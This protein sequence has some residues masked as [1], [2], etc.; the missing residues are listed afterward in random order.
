[1]K[2][3]FVETIVHKAEGR[4][5]TF[6]MGRE[7]YGIEIQRVREIMGFAAIE[8][9]A[10]AGPSIRGVIR[11][12]GKVVPVLDL[13]Q[14]FGLEGAEIQRGS[15]VVTVLVKGWEGPC[16]LGLLVDGIREVVQ[17]WTRDLEEAA[18]MEGDPRE[19]FLFGLARCQDRAVLLLDVDKVA[20][21]EAVEEIKLSWGGSHEGF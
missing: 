19:E 16:W 15:C 21:E 3:Q 7:E 12:R 20:K 17:V 13:R 2:D 9:I 1:V 18:V 4:Y 11:L 5:L 14:R 8:T 10:D 6:S